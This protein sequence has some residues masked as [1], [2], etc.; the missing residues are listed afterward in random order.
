MA[1]RI[2]PADF[3]P[4]GLRRAGLSGFGLGL[5]CLLWLSGNI[6]GT[7]TDFHEQHVRMSATS[8]GRWSWAIYARD[9]VAILDHGIAPTEK[10]ARREVW[11]FLL[12]PWKDT[13]D[14]AN[15]EANE[16]AHHE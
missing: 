14:W 5:I 8:D 4:S 9:E 7:V 6:K 2:R 10:A 13:N 1:I 15:E 12:N 16:E 3:K 11:A